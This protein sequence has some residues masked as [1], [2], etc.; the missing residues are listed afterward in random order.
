MPIIEVN[1]TERLSEEKTIKIKSLLGGNISI[2]P[3]KPEERVMVIFNE[4]KTIFFGGKPGPAALISV[5]LKGKQ[6]DDSYDTFSRLAIDTLVSTLPQI[7]KERIYVTY[8][9]ID[10]VG[11]GKD[12]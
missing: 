9:I 5:T 1:T 11:W 7:P 3:G 2:F 10:Q 8:R 6:P 4:E 12:I